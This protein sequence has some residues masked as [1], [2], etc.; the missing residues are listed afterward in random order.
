[1]VEGVG[2]VTVMCSPTQ[3]SVSVHEHR[4]RTIKTRTIDNML[5]HNKF[6]TDIITANNAECEKLVSINEIDMILYLDGSRMVW[7]KLM[8][9]EMEQISVG[10]DSK[11]TAL[12]CQKKARLK[13]RTAT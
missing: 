13:S 10:T 5:Q 1:M 3:L 9:E 2:E 8:S 7:M 6:K 12:R 11:S 4:N